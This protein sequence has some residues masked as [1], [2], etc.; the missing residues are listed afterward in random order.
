M[1]P[2]LPM[3]G[4]LGTQS[5]IFP[6]GAAGLA[7]YM[8][9]WVS[10]Q[11]PR[12][13]Q[14]NVYDQMWWQEASHPSVSWTSVLP[15][16][17]NATSSAPDAASAGMRAAPATMLVAQAAPPQ[18][19]APGAAARDGVLH[20][21]MVTSTGHDGLQQPTTSHALDFEQLSATASTR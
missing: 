6:H 19:R 21:T 12:P 1:L 9:M 16:H 11:L 17:G 15:P 3:G 14:P 7:V 8:L 2:G 5:V 13:F 18:L 4:L 10:A 20:P